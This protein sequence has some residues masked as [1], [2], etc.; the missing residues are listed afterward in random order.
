VIYLGIDPGVSGALAV[1]DGTDVRLFDVPTRKAKVG[2]VYLAGAMAD[3]VR[4]QIDC[5]E[6][7]GCFAMLEE[8]SIRP[9]ESGRSALKIGKGSGIW[10][11]V[12][13]GASVPYEMPLPA[14]WKREFR[15]IGLDKVASRARAC[16]LFPEYRA[17]L[18]KR[19]PDYSEALLLAEYARRRTAGGK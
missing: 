16:E 1:I 4:Q 2:S 9:G 19:R 3:L 7:R 5:G 11:G 12:L 18:L 17:E 8:V 13:A 15:L 10:E 14:V 6:P